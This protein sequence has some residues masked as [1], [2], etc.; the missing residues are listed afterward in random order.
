MSHANLARLVALAA[1]WGGSFLFIRMAVPVLGPAW[2]AELRVLL[3]AL[4]MLAYARAIGLDLGMRSRWKDY[5]IAGA[6]NT[7]MPWGLYAFA[8]QYLSASHMSILNAMTPLFTS[9]CGAIW[10]GERFT[11]R[12]AAG[13]L[14]G[15]AGV[16]VLTGLGPVA[17]TPGMLLGVLASLGACLGYALGGTFVKRRLGDAPPLAVSAA[18]LVF[19]SIA[20]APLL[21]P[22]PP[23]SALSPAVIVA[24]LGISLL[25]SALAYL[26]YFRLLA[27][28][29]PT[30]ALTVTF[31]IPVFGVLWGVTLLGEPLGRETLLGGGMVLAATALVLYR[32]ASRKIAG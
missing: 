8:G 22:P 10:L 32:G 21:P 5:A 30:R 13:L 23:A 4:A 18:C 26:L 17:L 7:A 31:L 6:L 15:I 16:A 24:V 25:C 2:F 20:T 11:P 29:G 28:V 14:L 3:A 27:D 9:I 19:A 1:L 12:L